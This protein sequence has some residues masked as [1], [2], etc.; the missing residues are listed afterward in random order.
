MTSL[1][2]SSQNKKFGNFVDLIISGEGG[3]FCELS[4]IFLE[5]PLV[6]LTNNTSFITIRYF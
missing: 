3:K 4:F 1:K 5:S 2:N 6:Y